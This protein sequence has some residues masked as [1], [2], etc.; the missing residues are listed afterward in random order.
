MD[1]PKVLPVVEPDIGKAKYCHPNLPQ[2]GV[3][4][5]GGGVV[6]LMISPT[7]TGKT[8]I[9]SNVLLNE[10]FWGQYFFDDVQVISNT[11]SNDV[12]GRFIKK[13]FHCHDMYDDKIIDSIIERQKSFD[14]EDQPEI[15]LILDD[16]LGSLSSQGNGKGQGSSIVKLVTRARHWN[17][18]LCAITTQKFKG[19]IS[20]IIRANAKAITVGSP[21]PNQKELI[22]IAEEYAD[23]FGLSVDQWMKLYRKATPNRYDFLY[24]DLQSTPHRMLHNFEKVIY[25][26]KGYSNSDDDLEDDMDVES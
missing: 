14:K 18:K 19:S 4:V 21:M 7:G 5:P 6:W 25:V 15:A 24:M 1:F 11:I 13:A 17:F 3:G 2:P 26:A 9:L 10:S 20:P 12:T 22:A 8:T 23:A 16:C